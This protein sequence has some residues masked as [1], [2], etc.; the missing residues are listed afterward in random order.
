MLTL[1]GRDWGVG[2]SVGRTVR[3]AASRCSFAYQTKTSALCDPDA[4]CD[5]VATPMVDC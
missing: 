5:S 3:A 1:K 4:Q 2:R